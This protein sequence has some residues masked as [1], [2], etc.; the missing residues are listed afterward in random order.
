MPQKTNKFCTYSDFTCNE[1]GWYDPK[2]YLPEEYELCTVLIDKKELPGWYGE[3]GKWEGPRIPK[4]KK[5]IFWKLQSY[6]DI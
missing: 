3:E 1:E 6:N 5:I 2:K 4:R